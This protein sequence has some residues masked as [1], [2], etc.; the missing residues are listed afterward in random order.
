MEDMEGFEQPY[1]LNAKGL[2][3]LQETELSCIGF[4]KTTD[5]ILEVIVETFL[6]LGF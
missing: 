1:S 4:E 5:L 6:L 2:V 3:L